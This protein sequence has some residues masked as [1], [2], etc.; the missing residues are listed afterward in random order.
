[1]K[2][3]RW[4]DIWLLVAA[5]LSLKKGECRLRNIIA[6]ADT[7]NHAVVN[8]EELSSAMVRLEEC[9]YVQIGRNPWTMICTDK[10]IRLVE[11]IAKKNSLAF[12]VWKE[13]EKILNVPSWDP[14]ESL[15]HPEN[16][17]Y[18]NGFSED[19]YRKEVVSYIEMMKSH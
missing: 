12:R 18:F 11:P 16:N 4:T 2:N 1:M 15:P 19:E 8:Y 6:V 10:G 5:Y 7:I 3:L 14:S 13:V 17:M 9:G